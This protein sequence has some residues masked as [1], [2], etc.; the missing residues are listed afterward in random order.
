MPRPRVIIRSCSEYDA[1]AI[2]VLAREAMLELG[3]A[4]EG[5][6]LV[7]PNVVSAGEL[8]QH[9]Y[10]RPEFVEGVLLALKDRDE[11]RVTEL[12]VGE[13]SGIS[14][15]TRYSFKMGGYYSMLRRVGGVKAHHFDEV[16]Q[17]EV[18][19]HHGGRLRSSLF[20]PAPVAEADVFVNCPKFKAHPWTTVTFSMKNYIGIQDDPHRLLDHDHLLN[21][22]VADLQYVTQPRF[23]AVD[24]IVAGQ[25]RM[26]TPIPFDLGLVILGN[27]QV[28]VDS[29][30]SRIIGLDPRDIEHI[31]LARER[32]FGPTD[33]DDIELSGDV[34]L[35]AAQK[36]AE[37]FEKG[38]IRVEDYFAGTNIR[39][40][41]GPPPGNAKDYCWGGCPGALEEAIEILR[42]FDKKTDEKLPP[43]HLVFGAYAGNIEARPDEK[44]VFIGDCARFDG[45]IGDRPIQISST[46]VDREHKSPRD[47]VGADIF[48][49]MV[50]V[51]ANL[52]RSRKQQVLRMP[53]CPVSVAEQVL[54]LVRL[55]GLSNPYF[56][57]R[58]TLDFVP[59]YLSFRAR[60]LVGQMIGKPYN[61]KEPAVRGAGRPE[62]NLPPADAE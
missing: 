19:L 3:V 38:L 35:E 2:R 53:G 20:T 17:V 7:K 10:T 42:L 58:V 11:G 24:A 36:R 4:P 1:Q 5:K 9:A 57:A 34:S 25:G 60:K 31:E 21:R 12:A 15:P 8:F 47:A 61:S 32:G 51:G 37:G 50:G 6:T 59:C 43:L 52:W 46:Y 41:A 22:K 44:V 55:G 49:K 14:I 13:R 56:D 54:A 23:I 18:P 27:N 39:A 33:L 48:A 30:C 28:A 45:K 26:L 29:V 62:Q 16:P 40:Y